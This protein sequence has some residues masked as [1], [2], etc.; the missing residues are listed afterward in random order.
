MANKRSQQYIVDTALEIA[1]QS[2]FEARTVSYIPRFMANTSLPTKDLNSNEYTRNNGRYT[3]HLLAPKDIGLPYGSYARQLLI[4][5]TTQAKILSCR[6]IHLGNSQARLLNSMGIQSSGG[7]NGTT[8]AFKEQ[9]KRLLACSIM[10]I[11]SDSSSWN[12]ESIR[13]SNNATLAW[14]PVT[15]NK[16]EANICLDESFFQDVIQH[17]VPIDQRVIES[18]SHYPMATDIY[19][20]LTYRYYKMSC[21]QSISWEQLANQFGNNYARKTSFKKKFILATKRV[22]LLYPA[23][24]FSTSD[25]GILLYPSPPHVS[26]S[27]AKKSLISVENLVDKLSYPRI[28]GDIFKHKRWQKH[29]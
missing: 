29:A 14:S 22:S 10:W 5:L 11:S 13:I 15:T 12:M 20:W 7:K 17:A 26:I 27:A 23:A 19:C 1:N 8:R 21:P 4:Y 3:L 28:K 16:W 2:A 6:E 9:T 18:C 25:K 24:K